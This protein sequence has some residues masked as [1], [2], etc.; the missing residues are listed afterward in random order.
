ML[1]S[2]A[3]GGGGGMGMGYMSGVYG[4]SIG[5]MGQCMHAMC[6]TH[7]HPQHR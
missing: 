6:H 1:E 5:S 3:G 4:F 2:G 7:I